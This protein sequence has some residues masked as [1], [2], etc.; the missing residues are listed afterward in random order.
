M[1]TYILDKRGTDSLRDYLYKCVKQD[2]L[3]GRLKAGEKLPSKRELAKHLE[4]SV[5]TVEN[6]YAQLVAE[7]YVTARQKKGYYVNKIE[8][9]KLPQKPEQPAPIRERK[10]ESAPACF[11]D[12]KTNSVSA[13]RFP[14]SVWARLM[15]EVIAERD[16]ELLRPAPYN[17]VLP[18]RREIAKFLY[19]FRGLTVDPEQIVVGAG[20]EVL[21]NLIVQ[22]LGRNNIFAV[23]TPGYSKIADIYTVNAVEKRYV[24]L[25]QSGISMKALRESGANIVHISPAHHYPTGI[26]TPIARRQELLRW[27]DEESGRYIIEDDYDS[28]FR[29]Q[30]RPIPTIQ[31]IDKQEKVIYVNTFSKTLAPSV[32]ISYMVLPPHLLREY[33]EKMG[34]YVCTVPSFEQYTLAKFMSTGRFEQHLS[35]MRKFY[36][37]QRDVLISAI[38]SSGFRHRVRIMEENAGLH[39]ILKVETEKSDREIV[40]GA[41]E[42]GVRVACLSEYM[43]EPDRKSEHNLIINYSGI[44]GRDVGEAVRRL[45]EAL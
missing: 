22:L 28:E 29:F 45:G 5:V 38:Q 40:A 25:D 33:R 11:V 26:V 23:E 17:G 41:A 31:S 20:T 30:G 10:A 43:L 34:F 12:F 35:R 6:A 3:D 9:L 8:T 7:G 1:L 21:Y 24:P 15:R 4:V 16:T 2:I 44:S 13:E 27:A 32:R 18:L 19:N 14:F 42:K 36:K 37:S 39:F